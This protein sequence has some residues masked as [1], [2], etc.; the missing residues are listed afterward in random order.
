MCVF[1]WLRGC[2]ILSAM[3]YGHPSKSESGIRDT[4][5]SVGVIPPPMLSVVTNIYA[6]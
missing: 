2:F 6:S 4:S 1:V 5:V 3:M